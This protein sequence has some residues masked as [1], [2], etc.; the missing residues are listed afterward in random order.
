MFSIKPLYIETSIK[1]FI[2]F[3]LNYFS[4]NI[5]VLRYNDIVKWIMMN[6]ITIIYL[7]LCGLIPL[8]EN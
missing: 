1:Y 8:T 4:C 7:K 5:Y 2:A 3:R 6:C